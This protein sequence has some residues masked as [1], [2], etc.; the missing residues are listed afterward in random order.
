MTPTAVSAKGDIVVVS[1]D[2]VSCAIGRVVQHMML[3][4][5]TC[6]SLIAFFDPLSA[7]EPGGCVRCTAHSVAHQLT[8]SEHIKGTCTYS[9]DAEVLRCILPYHVRGFSIG[10][11]PVCPSASSA[12]RATA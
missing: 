1:S 10:P 3:E 7:L 6:I 5:K 11:P 4:D 8:W 9:I 2:M 12:S